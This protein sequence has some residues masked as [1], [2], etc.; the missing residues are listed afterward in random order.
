MV[1]MFVILVMNGDCRGFSYLITSL[2]IFYGIGIFNLVNL[3]ASVLC[4][5]VTVHYAPS[6]LNKFIIHYSFFS[7]FMVYTVDF[8]YVS[9]A[10]LLRLQCT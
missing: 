10:S 6:L 8:N 7:I 4:C 1:N 5:H 9:D 3:A 2:D